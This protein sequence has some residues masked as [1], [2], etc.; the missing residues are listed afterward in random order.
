M[1]YD[2]KNSNCQ[3]IA[4]NSKS[5]RDSVAQEHKEKYTN[6][7]NPIPRLTPEPPNF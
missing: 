2:I 7:A 5:D 4:N 3:L 6:K 1:C